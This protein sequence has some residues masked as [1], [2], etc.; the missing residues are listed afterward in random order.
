MSLDL[1]E[2][3][4]QTCIS[5][6]RVVTLKSLAIAAG[7]DVNEACKAMTKFHD[8]NQEL[9]ATY[10]ISGMKFCGAYSFSIVGA[11]DLEGFIFIYHD[12]TFLIYL[13]I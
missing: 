13:G 4:L 7:C 3:E 11:P 12:N 5:E 8:N 2:T 6:G 9:F 1:L 10:L